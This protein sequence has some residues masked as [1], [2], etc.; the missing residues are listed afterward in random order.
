MTIFKSKIKSISFYTETIDN[1]FSNDEE[2]NKELQA[3]FL[4]RCFELAR[5]SDGFFFDTEDGTYIFPNLLENESGYIVKD[6]LFEVEGL[7]KEV[8]ETDEWKPIEGVCPS[9]SKTGKKVP[10]YPD[11][12]R[13]IQKVVFQPK[14][15]N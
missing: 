1:N 10:N 3:Y 9:H 15:E 14:E 13:F 5:D 6:A 2:L 7:S 4:N 12:F 11:D 8:V